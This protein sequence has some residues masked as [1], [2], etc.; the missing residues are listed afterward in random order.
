MRLSVAPHYGIGYRNLEVRLRNIALHADHADRHNSCERKTSASSS[1]TSDSSGSTASTAS[2][3]K[4]HLLQLNQTNGGDAKRR[5]LDA[6]AN[7]PIYAVVNLKNKYE[8]RAKKKLAD[9]AGN[10]TDNC[11][12]RRERPNSFHVNSGEYEEVRCTRVC[13]CR[14]RLREYVEIQLRARHHRRAFVVCN[15]NFQREIEFP[16]FHFGYL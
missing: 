3:S 14:A 5:P 9:D 12:L 10:F 15:L 16:L 4:F 7:E 1:I 13:V 2:A 11:I 8:H 6:N